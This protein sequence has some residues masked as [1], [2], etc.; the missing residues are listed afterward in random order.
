MLCTHT[1]DAAASLLQVIVDDIQKR[2]TD[3]IVV[4]IF[5]KKLTLPA[6]AP[7][8]TRPELWNKLINDGVLMPCGP[9]G[10]CQ[11]RSTRG[12]HISDP[13][14]DPFEFVYAGVR[15]RRP[16]VRMVNHT[17]GVSQYETS[18]LIAST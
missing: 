9:K 15:I 14:R 13:S 12:A 17:G 18:S 4:K 8:M 10:K 5:V 1:R 6:S 2:Q 7:R 3:S 11:G 16:P